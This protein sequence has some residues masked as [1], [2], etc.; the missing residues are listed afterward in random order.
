MRCLGLYLR[1]QNWSPQVIAAIP[2]RQW[3][4]F[5]T[6]WAAEEEMRNEKRP[7]TG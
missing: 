3:R 1:N 4:Y 6:L 5:P 7:G 2:L